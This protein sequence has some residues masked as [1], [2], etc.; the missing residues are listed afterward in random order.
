M[1]KFCHKIQTFCK[2]HIW[3]YFNNL[4]SKKLL[5]L[6]EDFPNYYHAIKWSYL[7]DPSWTDHYK[8]MVVKGTRLSGSV[9]ISLTFLFKGTAF[10][11]IAVHSPV[12]GQLVTAYLTK[13]RSKLS[14]QNSCHHTGSLA[15][16]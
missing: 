11:K 3:P 6:R 10:H 13:V 9:V 2:C 12:G 16:Q 15:I 14:D 4:L 5:L 7:L 8:Y 1:T